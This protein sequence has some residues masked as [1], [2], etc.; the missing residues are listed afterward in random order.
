[1][2][3]VVTTTPRITLPLSASVATATTNPYFQQP[4]RNFSSGNNSNRRRIRRRR[5]GG[6]EIGASQESDMSNATS[7]ETNNNNSSNS[8]I[9]STD[10]IRMVKDK[11]LFLKISNEFLTKTAKA[12][13]PMKAYN[14]VFNIHISTNEQGEK[15]TISLKPSEG[16]YVLQVDNDMFTLSL[17]SPMS[18]S[19]TY[20]LCQQTHEFIG[21]VDDHSLEGMLVRDL[22]RHCNG[23]PQF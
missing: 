8:N 1:M 21:M 23:L 12:L 5:N 10:N 3:S 14:E 22:I 17:L 9:I 11:A 15:L 2:R 13:E 19:Y 4:N 18:G 16:Q 7:D 6:A 20:V